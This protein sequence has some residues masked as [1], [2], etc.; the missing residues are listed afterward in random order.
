MGLNK[1]LHS[2]KLPSRLCHLKWPAKRRQLDEVQQP[3]Y[4]Y[5]IPGDTLRQC[6]LWTIRIF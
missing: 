2:E 6:P 5:S 4:Q 3:A 1:C